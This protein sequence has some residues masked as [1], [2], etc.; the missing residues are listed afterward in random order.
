MKA[1][2]VTKKKIFNHW[3]TGD[4]GKITDTNQC[5]LVQAQWNQL[6][7]FVGLSRYFL[8]QPTPKNKPRE[9]QEKSFPASP[10]VLLLI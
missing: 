8:T 9:T 10:V 7:D 4:T 6:F 3:G 2:K 1:T 5:R